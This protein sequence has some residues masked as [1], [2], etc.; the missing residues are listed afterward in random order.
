MPMIAPIVS[1]ERRGI[2][3]L[4]RLP[5]K[6]TKLVTWGAAM[7]KKKTMWIKPRLRAIQPCQLRRAAPSRSLAP[8]GAPKAAGA[9]AI[10]I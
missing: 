4:Y 2:A 7:I 5:E 3:I 1:L 6:G 10:E 9:A 8:A